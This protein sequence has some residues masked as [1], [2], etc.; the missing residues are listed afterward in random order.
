[1]IY[2]ESENIVA[3][4]MHGRSRASRTHEKEMGCALELLCAVIQHNN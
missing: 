2:R 1:M 3:D 4:F